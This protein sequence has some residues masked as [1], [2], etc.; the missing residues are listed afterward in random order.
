[1]QS[2]LAKKI[3]RRVLDGEATPLSYPIHQVEAAFRVMDTALTPELMKPWTDWANRPK[4][5]PAVLAARQQ[6]AEERR[7][8]T[9]AALDHR[10]QERAERRQTAIE[11]N[12]PFIANRAA[13][14]VAAHVQTPEPEEVPTSEPEEVQVTPQEI[15][16]AAAIAAGTVPESVTIEPEPP[17][18]KTPDMSATTVAELR[19]E[20]KKRG[21]KGYSAMNKADLIA[22]LTTP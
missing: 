21:V 12:R 10:R 15:A 9:M 14:I 6:A 5:D 7:A 11:R 4:E 20:A 8:A 3:V 19:A 22:A 17:V 18:E 1:M 2:R 13:Q 16:V